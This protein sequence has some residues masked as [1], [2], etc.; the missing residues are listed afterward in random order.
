MSPEYAYC[1]HV[2]TKSDMFS[3]GVIVLEMVTGRKSNSTY[4]CLDSTSLLS[5]AWKK[6]SSGSAADVVDASLNGK[7]P[8][9]EVLNCLEVGLLCVQENPT[10]RPDATEV[11]VQLGRSNS[12]SDESRREP[13]RPA[14]SFGPG[15]GRAALG[16]AVEEINALGDDFKMKPIEVIRIFLRLFKDPMYESIITFILQ[17]DLKTKT[18]KETKKNKKKVIIEDDDEEDD[19]EEYDDEEDDDEE[20]PKP[21]K[22][23]FKSQDSS[24]EEEED[25][26]AKHKKK[27]YFN[28]DKSKGKGKAQD[29]NKKFSRKTLVGEWTSHNSCDESSS[30]SDEE[31]AGLAMIKT[32]TTRAL[33]P[34]PTCLMAT[35]QLGE[36]ED[37]SS[38]DSDDEELS[39]VELWSMLEQARD[40]AVKKSKMLDMSDASTM[41]DELTTL[42]EV[43]S[44]EPFVLEEYH[45]LKEERKMVMDGFERL[46]RG[47]AIHKEILGRNL[48]NNVSH[49][50]LG[51][52]PAAIDIIRT[53]DCI[54]S[55]IKPVLADDYYCER[56]CKDG[57]ATKDCLMVRSS[58][59]LPNANLF[60]ENTH[61]KPF[62][63][64]DGK[65]KAKAFGL[66]NKKRKVKSIWVPKCT[67]DLERLATYKWVPKN[68]T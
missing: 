28:K 16:A 6:W 34:P 2:S 32:T 62:R 64:K 39:C 60:H 37:E 55:W 15:G 20:C 57:H 9:S 24:E 49:W 54:P 53:S 48:V 43:S 12:V 51:S 67:V 58:I 7:Y 33:P 56:C 42:V 38:N 26:K 14:F 1:G 13:S 19:D 45:K 40:I 36:S 17:G 5:Y 18:M 47:R 3:F 23:A 10:D 25:P 52:Y 30:S 35:S 41:C 8:E 31:V 65:V 46:T 66:P 4:E 59:V 11:V 61:F 44:F 68:K 29:N 21:K 27:R 22:E 50:G 63:N